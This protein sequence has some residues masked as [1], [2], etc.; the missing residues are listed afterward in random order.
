MKT[1]IV[2]IISFVLGCVCQLTFGGQV[3]KQTYTDK[4]G[5]IVTRAYTN[6][7]GIT[8]YYD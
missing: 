1:F 6:S 4:R 3:S 8:R 2:L 5:T 7:N